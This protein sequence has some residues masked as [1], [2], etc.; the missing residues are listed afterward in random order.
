MKHVSD[1]QLLQL[2]QDSMNYN[3]LKNNCLHIVP[4]DREGPGFPQMSFSW[5][6]ME[7]YKRKDN[8]KIKKEFDIAVTQKRRMEQI[9]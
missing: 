3:W 4:E 7:Y 5:D 2:I 8:Y 9:K 6:I 1:D